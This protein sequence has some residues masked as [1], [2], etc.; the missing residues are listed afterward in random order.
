[1]LTHSGW[2]HRVSPSTSDILRTNL[3]HAQ[4]SESGIEPGQI[5]TITGSL[6]SFPDG[7]DHYDTDHTDL[8]S[9]CD[10]N[11]LKR[12]LLRDVRYSSYMVTAENFLLFFFAAMASIFR[13]GKYSYR[14]N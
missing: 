10:E 14:K 3:T 12:N 11:E 2:P 4:S 7:G 13:Q 1:M 6:A 9:E 5:A 8:G